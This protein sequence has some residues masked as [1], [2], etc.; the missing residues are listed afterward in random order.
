MRRTSLYQLR[1]KS[2]V[3]EQELSSSSSDVSDC[4]D[5][6]SKVQIKDVCEEDNAYYSSHDDVIP[7]TDIYIRLKH[8]ISFKQDCFSGYEANDKEFNLVNYESNELFK[9]YFSASITSI[10]CLPYTFTNVNRL[11]NE[12]ERKLPSIYAWCDINKSFPFEFAPHFQDHI[13]KLYTDVGIK[14]HTILINQK[15]EQFAM[16]KIQKP[17]D[18]RYVFH[19]IGHGY[20]TVTENNLWY[21]SFISKKYE[22]LNISTVMNIIKMPNMI[23][24]DCSNA[25]ALL[26]K[27]KSTC[28]ASKADSSSMSSNDCIVFGATSCGEEIPEDSKLPQDLFSCTLFDPLKTM[29]MSH[30]MHKYRIQLVDDTFPVN[31]TL[32]SLWNHTK[33]SGKI[34]KSLLESVA[35]AIAVDG[36][37]S[38]LYNKYFKIDPTTSN[39]FRNFIIAQNLLYKFR[40]H[41]VSIPEL[42][43]LSQHPLWKQ[44]S[45]LLDASISGNTPVEQL[46]E[47]FYSRLISSMRI[48]VK[49][50]QYNYVK[51]SH[52]SL[53]FSYLH[54]FEDNKPVPLIAEYIKNHIDSSVIRVASLSVIVKRISEFRDDIETVHQLLF[55][56][57]SLMINT[58][59]KD[60]NISFCDFFQ[61]ITDKQINRSTRLLA[62]SILTY[63]IS[64]KD[65]LS[66]PVADNEVIT[67]I[68]D[69]ISNSDPE[70]LV[71]YLILLYNILKKLRL[72]PECISETGIHVQLTYLLFHSDPPIRAAATGCL[73]ALIQDYE[74]DIN[75]QLVYCSL[76]SIIDPSFYTRFYFIQLLKRFALTLNSFPELKMDFNYK[77][78][79]VMLETIF[80]KSNPNIRD[81]ESYINAVDKEMAD[82][83]S[84]SRII[85]IMLKIIEYYKNDPHPGISYIAE[86]VSAYIENRKNDVCDRPESCYDELCSFCDQT[87]SLPYCSD[88]IK[89]LS[90]LGKQHDDALYLLS[91]RNLFYNTSWTLSTSINPKSRSSFIEIK[92]DLEVD[93][94]F[95]VDNICEIQFSAKRKDALSIGAN[96]HVKFVLFDTD[97]SSVILAT[98]NK[99]FFVNEKCQKKYI[100]SNSEITSVSTVSYGDIPAILYG[101][102]NGSVFLW[103]VNRGYPRLAFRITPENSPVNTLFGG[104]YIVATSENG[105]YSLWS[106]N[107]LSLVKDGSFNKGISAILSEGDTFTCCLTD[108]SIIHFNSQNINR[109]KSRISKNIKKL[110]LFRGKYLSLDSKGRIKYGRKILYENKLVQSVAVCKQVTSHIFVSQ[111]DSKPFCL[112]INGDKYNL[113]KDIPIGSLLAVHKKLPFICFVSPCGEIFVVKIECK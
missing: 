65:I 57:H 111:A 54:S 43:D 51:P 50:K 101:T 24:L 9:E 88:D 96:E 84:R 35:E 58:P 55:I 74:H 71:W 33:K 86:K 83:T 22:P 12:D 70:E 72:P 13:T 94:T 37:S 77:T 68:M 93:P 112:S 3:S 61:I 60:F 89:T 32:S 108:G 4:N 19:Y 106:L 98:S 45:L 85:A 18:E 7:L 44:W 1:R 82:I 53:L 17:H 5:G 63:D 6:K 14:K 62:V 27:I 25:G 102:S 52:L 40:M 48:Y 26:P 103:P 39:L 31:M 42:P 59:S 104:G 75:I 21:Y 64:K 36:I 23:I 2:F 16:M 10:Y 56:T 100:T 29:V 28:S 92:P 8:L 107:Y 66:C 95:V 73:S 87:G 41:P 113:F 38:E 11:S 78:L 20:P 81:Y 105:V 49:H 91:M 80:E 97:T 99:I 67:K 69:C 30:I 110:L 76:I 79:T 46:V 15:T 90:N 34:L 109:D 47:E